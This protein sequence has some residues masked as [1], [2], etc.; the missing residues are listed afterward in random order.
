[1]KA[2]AA[3]VKL[4]CR[5]SFRS[6][7]FQLLL[8]LLLGCVAFV[9]TTVGAGNAGEFIRVS[10]LYSLSGVTGILMLSALWVSCY[11]MSHDIDNYQLHMVVCK[12]VSRLTLW[13]AK[14]TGVTIVH[15]FL[16]VLAAAAIYA[17]IVYRFE[18]FQPGDFPA[19]DRAAIEAER[20]KIRSEVMVGREVFLPERPDYGQLARERVRET[21][22]RAEERRLKLDLSPKAQ[23]ELFKEAFK[24]V[25]AADSRVNAG[26]QRLWVYTGLP[27]KLDQPISLR[28]RPYVGKVDSKDQRIT[29][30][31]WFLGIPM[32]PRDAGNNV[33]QKQ[34]NRYDLALTPLSAAPEQQ[35]SG[36]F[37][38]KTLRPEWGFVTPDR[39]VYV[40][41]AN[42]DPGKSLHY[43]QPMDGPKL[44][45]PVCGFFANYCRAIIVAA[46]AIVMLCAIS[47]AF[48]G[49]LTM[50]T[51][52]FVVASYLMFGSFSL[53]LTDEEFF[54]ESAM[55]R[56]GQFVAHCLLAVIVPLQEFEFSTLVAGGELISFGSIW[57]LIW[58]YGFCRVAPLVLLGV[59]LY[60]RRELG[61]VLRSK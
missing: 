41:V 28:Y 50:P 44:L 4:T 29:R 16:L 37:H 25:V 47:C 53:F 24:E 32:K 30:L 46:L 17:I 36:V 26:S 35:L 61:L 18:S 15:L 34:K 3:I 42:F 55:D 12:P 27:A 57:H 10:L 52:I 60:R 59:W 2:F 23:E 8:L 49:F 58:F 31:Q 48:G 39:K 40:A 11:T 43:Y 33:F 56:F 21:A 22:R 1:M 19:A 51:A 6:H 14:C 20:E 9:P 38:E 5:H 7:I 54:V 45:I 13:L